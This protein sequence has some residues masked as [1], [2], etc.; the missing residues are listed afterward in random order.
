MFMKMKIL[1]CAIFLVATMSGFAQFE[2]A[3]QTY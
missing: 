2:A 1:I 3:K